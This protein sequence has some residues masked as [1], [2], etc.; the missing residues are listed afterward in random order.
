M[1]RT[2]KS[3]VLLMN[4]ILATKRSLFYSSFIFFVAL[5]VGNFYSTTCTADS[6]TQQKQTVV[7]S[8]TELASVQFFVDLPKLSY[9]F[10]FIAKDEKTEEND[11]DQTLDLFQSI[12]QAPNSPYNLQVLRL[13]AEKTAHSHKTVPLFILYH[14]WKSYVV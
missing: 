3:C 8:S 12:F 14:S 5:V 7:L 13:G 4:S 6:S 11:E 1:N 9:L 10:G 2:S